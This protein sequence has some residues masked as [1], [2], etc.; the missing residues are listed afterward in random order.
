MKKNNNDIEKAALLAEPKAVEIEKYLKS[1]LTPE[2]YTHVLS[3]RELALD[4]AKRYGA[5]L[6]KVNLAVLL[7]DCAKWMRTSEQYE[8]AANH[9]IQ[10]DEIERHNPSLLHAL[11]G[12]EFAVSHFDVDNPE[13]LNAIRLHTTGATGMTLIDKILYVADFA[14]PK[15]NYAEAHSVREIAYQ[16]LNEAVFEVSRYKIEHLLAKGVLIHPHTIDAYNSA[17]REISEPTR[18]Q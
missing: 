3:V 5:D 14:E 8:A 6:R 2:R 1:K 18:K 17:L 4:L 15:R 10:L 13:I 9:E 12:A 11:I 16:N 7:H